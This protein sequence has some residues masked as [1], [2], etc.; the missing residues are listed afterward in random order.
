LGIYT[1]ELIS[2]ETLDANGERD[3]LVIYLRII[4]L[5]GIKVNPINFV[6]H[7][8]KMEIPI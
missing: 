1:N 5:G 2:S 3:D 6:M 4:Y 8:T 7:R